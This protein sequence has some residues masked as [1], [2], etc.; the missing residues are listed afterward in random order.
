MVLAAA[1]LATAW[2]TTGVRATGGGGDFAAAGA[3]D[4]GTVAAG[5]ADAGAAGGATTG[6]LGASAR[7]AAVLGV[8]AGGASRALAVSDPP[9]N[10]SFS[11]PSIFMPPGFP[12]LIR[13]GPLSAAITGIPVLVC[14]IIADAPISAASTTPMPPANIAKRRVAGS[15][16]RRRRPW[17]MP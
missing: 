17:P 12:G 10:T 3:G 6:G 5:D 11:A 8:S 4:G 1:G 2:A 15:M 16:R 14:P 9:E 7:R 13:T